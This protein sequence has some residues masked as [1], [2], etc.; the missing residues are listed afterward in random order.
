MNN[1]PNAAVQITSQTEFQRIEKLMSERIE[2]T[3]RLSADF[4]EQILKINPHFPY[5]PS[6]PTLEMK[7]KEPIG[8][9]EHFD[10]KITLLTDAN[11]NLQ[12]TLDFFKT[13]V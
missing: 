10:Y 12:E 4:R 6:E 1:Y 5:R 2:H 7:T 13:L 8:M 11:N 3:T 9:Q